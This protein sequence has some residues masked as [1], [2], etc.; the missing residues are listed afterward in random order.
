MAYTGHAP[1]EE[2]SLLD[3]MGAGSF[4]ELIAALPES[5]LLKEPIPIPPGQSEMELR[6]LF[7]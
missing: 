1:Q 3:A 5:L 6:R 7:H 2:A 4:E